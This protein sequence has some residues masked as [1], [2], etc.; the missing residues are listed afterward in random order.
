MRVMYTL[1]V[2]IDEK[3]LF[4]NHV[5][6][7]I[8]TDFLTNYAED[9][10]KIAVLRDEVRGLYKVMDEEGHIIEC[11]LE[12]SIVECL[13]CSH[14]VAPWSILSLVVVNGLLDGINPCAF[15]ALIFFIALQFAIGF[16]DF[17][18]KAKRRVLLF[19]ST[20]IIAVYL[21][22]L[23]IGI[24]LKHMIEIIP[25]PHL[26]SKIGV[27]IL[28][29]AGVINILDYFWPGRGISLKLSPSRWKTA[30]NWMRKA[31]FPA[32]FVVG[33]IIALFEF[34]CTGGIYVA[35]LG[36][37]AMRTTF[38]EGFTYLLF[39]NIAFIFPLIVILVIA[40]NKRL[41][42]FSLRR[43]QQ[44]QG[45]YMTILVGIIYISL[46]AFLLSASLF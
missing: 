32:T 22:Y 41:M 15:A 44:H 14:S 4:I 39:Y 42:R 25:F 40:S 16:I 29:A 46:G 38:L 24:T 45:K 20:Y 26:V 27:V 30:R 31:T 17:A 11:K 23:T 35:I 36:M 2:C 1:V 9:Y 6:V 21:T 28:I 18:E 37:L 12:Q 8:I 10:A 33:V 43:W 13:P 3:F 7:G 19:G 5:P 34:P